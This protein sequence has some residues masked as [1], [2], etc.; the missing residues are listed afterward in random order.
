MLQL[1]GHP[2]PPACA[3]ASHHT[4]ARSGSPAAAVWGRPPSSRGGCRRKSRRAAKSH[5]D[6]TSPSLRALAWAHAPSC[7]RT[8]RGCQNTTWSTRQSTRRRCCL[9]TP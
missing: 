1:L 8:R 3:D 6:R 9:H 2:R 7:P 5:Q 4:R